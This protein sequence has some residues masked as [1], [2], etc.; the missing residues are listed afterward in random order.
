MNEPSLYLKTTVSTSLNYLAKISPDT[1][2][3]FAKMIDAEGYDVAACK[4]AKHLVIH[5]DTSNLP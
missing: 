4:L 3:Y 5:A 2:E 1:A